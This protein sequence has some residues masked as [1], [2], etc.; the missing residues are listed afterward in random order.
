[1][2]WQIHSKWIENQLNATTALDLDGA[3]GASTIHIGFVTDSVINPD[4]IN[5]YSQLTPV[6]TGTAWTGTAAL[7]NM[8]CGLD[9][10]SNVVFDADDPAPIPKDAAGGFANARAAVIFDVTSGAVLATAIE[11][12][13][14]GNV[15]GTLTASF[16]VAG[17][18]SFII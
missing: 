15:A 2:A 8:T 13:M 17:I 5:L 18:L 6:A 14:F 10:S 4:T 9:A 16:D 12:V 11:P 3:G 1:M 7:V